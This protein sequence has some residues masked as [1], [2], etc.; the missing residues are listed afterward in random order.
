MPAALLILLFALCGGATGV[1]AQPRHRSFTE[2]LTRHVEDGHVDYAALCQDQGL[3]EYLLQLSAVEPDTVS[4][5]ADRLAFWINAYNA[6]TL[7]AICAEYPVKSINEL[8]FGGLYLGTVLK[9]TV[10]DRRLIHLAES[11]LSLNQIEHEIIRKQFAEPRIHYA[12]VCAARSCPPLRGEAFEGNTL[13]AQLDDQARLFLNDP[14]QNR[15]V[16][17]ERRAQLSRILDWYGGDFGDGK[18]D[19]LLHVA[20]YLPEDVA[21]SLRADPDAWKVEHL[22]YDWSLNE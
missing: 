18:E 8:H 3:D 20:R 21:A 6:F 19:L 2:L 5:D 1:D 17:A 16:V 15:F 14:E 7:K 11:T 22:P 13:D 9:R 4:A 10:W 12:L